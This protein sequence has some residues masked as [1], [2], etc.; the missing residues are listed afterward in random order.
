[1]RTI[2]SL[3]KQRGVEDDGLWEL[4]VV[5]NN[6]QDRT[7]E[8]VESCAATARVKIRHIF[9]PQQ[10]KTYALNTGIANSC[11]DVTAFTDD[12]VVVDAGWLAAVLEATET[13]PHRAFGGK[14]VPLWPNSVPPWIQVTGLYAKPIVG[15]P[16]VAHDSGDEI[17]EYGEG[18][19]VPIGA[20]MFFRKEVFEK[21]GGFRTDLGPKGEIYGPYEDSEI[22]F[23]LKNQGESI[24]YFPQAVIYHPVSEHRLS[25]QYL[26]RH[27]W[28][29]GLTQARMDDDQLTLVRRAKTIL[30]SVLLV[31]IR[32]AKYCWTCG[33]GKP[34]MNM[35]HKCL[36][37]YQTGALYY[38]ALRTL[39]AH[40]PSR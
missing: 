21:Y 39:N 22:G 37:Y 10:G 40:S 12:D 20:N 36:L 17:K 15:S 30:R 6:S 31:A 5:D 28:N 11:G 34:A 32:L 33:R 24:L 29:A 3:L 2:G 7:R 27:F 25:Q 9:E 23:R 26:L 35:H 13:Y 1:M 14:V 8:V 38:H 19:W 16:V 4:L 18:M